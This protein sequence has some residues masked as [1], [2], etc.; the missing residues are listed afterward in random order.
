S[1]SLA[2][3][4]LS[5]VSVLII[6]CPCALGLATPAAVTVAMGKA[7]EKGIL[8][9]DAQALEV[10]GKV[11]AIAFDKTGPLTQGKPALLKIHSLATLSVSGLST[12]ESA[13]YWAA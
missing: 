10:L 5:A 6:S 11:R 4:L 12:E 2:E 8:I 1:H 13:L 7:T 3:S 9:R